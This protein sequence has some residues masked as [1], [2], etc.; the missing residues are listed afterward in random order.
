MNNSLSFDASLA[1]AMRLLHSSEPDA[2]EQLKSMLDECI[3]FRKTPQNVISKPAPLPTV[4][5][6]IS[7]NIKPQI[8]A[9]AP[10]PPIMVPSDDS[11][12]AVCK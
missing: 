7:T 12:C 4:K 1:K 6:V 9:P 5:P 11:Y 10:I 8:S 3:S 2:T